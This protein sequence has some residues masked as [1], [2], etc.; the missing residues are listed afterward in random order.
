MSKCKILHVTPHLGG[1]VGRCLSQIVAV[2]EDAVT[3]EF[4]LLERPIDKQFYTKIKTTNVVRHISF[5]SNLTEYLKKF[6]IIQIEFWNHPA[7]LHFLNMTKDFE[8]RR[9]FWCHISGCGDAILSPNFI[10]SNESIIFSSNESNKFY[11]TQ[12]NVVNSGF[13]FPLSV[14]SLL[15]NSR[16]RFDF[17]FAG[18][19][20]YR[21]VHSSIVGILKHAGQISSQEI[22]I[23][24][25]GE[26]LT[27]IKRQLSKHNMKFRGHVENICE[28][29]QNCRYL[30]YPL[31][32]QH[33]GTGENVI[34]EAM[35]LGCIPVLLN[36]PV[37]RAIMQDVGS[38]LC[39]DS[40]SDMKAAFKNLINTTDDS[41]KLSTDLAKLASGHYSAKQSVKL[42]TE[43]YDR[44]LHSRSV[45]RFS[46][47]RYFGITPREWF[48]SFH[49]NDV[50]YQGQR[51]GTKILT[52]GSFQHYQ[53][54]FA[55]SEKELG[56]KYDPL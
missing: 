14:D 31:S 42:L 30:L 50:T 22:N 26:D 28:Y 23:I 53:S 13:G 54:F 52:K 33:Y 1:G 35:S 20:D 43:V 6:D 56:F 46:F 32:P 36:N 27:I 48:A 18:Q 9:I 34:K 10:K 24:G 11:N 15:P 55:R 51:G 41:N 7:I 21:K 16:R 47:S 29:F 17:M 37:E 19:L 38:H 44:T 8:L 5:E 49:N 25:T 12:K 40:P 45:S 3:R 39:F 2:Q 4:L